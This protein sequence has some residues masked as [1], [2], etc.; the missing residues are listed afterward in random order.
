LLASMG[1]EQ[2]ERLS[3]DD[4]VKLGQRQP[5]RL[6]ETAADLVLRRHARRLTGQSLHL[7]GRGPEA[8]RVKTLTQ[9]A[10]ADAF[11]PR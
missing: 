8:G 5:G 9:T 1:F 7:H 2:R 6:G 3:G 11:R 10:S 4:A